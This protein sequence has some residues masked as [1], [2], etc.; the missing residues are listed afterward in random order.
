[1]YQKKRK[2]GKP[3]FSNEGT[4]RMSTSEA[5]QSSRIQIAHFM[6]NRVNYCICIPMYIDD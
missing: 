5:F 3:D 2:K 6:F 1:M 4:Q